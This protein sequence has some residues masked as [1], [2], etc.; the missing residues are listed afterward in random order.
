MCISMQLSTTQAAL[1]ARFKRRFN[2][3]GQLELPI[4]FANAFTQPEWP[5][6]T[7]EAPHELGPMNWGFVPSWAKVEPK[8]FLRTRMTYNCVSEEA[9]EKPVFR[10][11]LKR[12]RRCLIPVTKFF[13]HHHTGKGAKAPKIPY[14]IGLKDDE[15]FSLG[16]LYENGT[17]TILTTAAGPLM[18][19]IH[20]SKG[21]QVVVVP[22]AFEN[23]WLNPLLTTEDVLRFCQP[24]A[25]E[26]FTHWPISKRITQRDVD[27]NV[28]DITEPVEYPEFADVLP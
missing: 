6:V 15:I 27:P 12:G 2:T 5:V 17:F 21:R 28:P 25:D 19:R 23:D 22:R 7:T 9:A 11:A 20:N 4:H 18:S 8:E 14:A 26:D 13:E 16:G 3:S 10:D 1:E 24:I